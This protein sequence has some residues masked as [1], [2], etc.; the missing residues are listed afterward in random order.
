MA[1]F[2]TMPKM[3]TDESSVILRSG[4]GS[5]RS[6]GATKMSSAKNTTGYQEFKKGGYVQKKADGG[7]M[8]ALSDKATAKMAVSKAM[9]GQPQGPRPMPSKKPLTASTAFG[10]AAGMGMKKGGSWEGSAKD[11]A[12]DKKLA[13]KH[14][15]S[16]EKWES[17]SMDKKHDTQK[18]MK[19]LKSGGV[20]SGL[21]NDSKA[22]YKDGGS[23]GA[24]SKIYSSGV[25][26]MPHGTAPAPTKATLSGND[27]D[28]AK[29]KHNTSSLAT[30]SGSSLKDYG[31]TGNVP[32]TRAAGYKSGGV[33]PKIK[34]G[35][36]VP[37]FAFGGPSDQPS[38]QVK[39]CEGGSMGKKQYADGGK[40]S[41]DVTMGAEKI[42]Q[43]KK[44]PSAPVRINMLSGTFKKGGSVGK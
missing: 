21:K 22:C 39:A 31:A 11:E 24:A 5:S 25:S 29:T 27:A 19:G 42:P 6:G 4:S 1:E 17:S 26:S 2:K 28:Y 37:K 15:M 36:T 32:K 7:A 12:Q 3:S 40:V 14:G 18:S 30:R 23:I 41:K 13:K 16:M 20:T 8:G 38:M 33:V 35:G 44:P 10:K 43:G 9:K 34:T